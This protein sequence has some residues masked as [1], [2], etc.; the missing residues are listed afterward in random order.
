MSP[1]RHSISMTFSNH[2]GLARLKPGVA[3]EQAEGEAAARIKGL[4]AGPSENE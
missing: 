3:P 1:G 4:D 2:N